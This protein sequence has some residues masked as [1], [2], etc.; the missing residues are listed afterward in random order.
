MFPMRLGHRLL[1]FYIINNIKTLLF[2][3]MIYIFRIEKLDIVCG[4]K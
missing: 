1:I 2:E 3:C 4:K